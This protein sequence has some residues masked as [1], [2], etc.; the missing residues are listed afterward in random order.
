M[1]KIALALLLSLGVTTSAYAWGDRE[2][3]ILSGIAGILLLNKLNE[4]PV[5][6]QQQQPPI[7]ID[8]VIVSPAPPPRYREYYSCLVRVYDPRYGVFR[9]EVMTCV[10]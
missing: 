1:K 8:P 5:T 3:G 7:V 10:K 2:Q 9:N 6:Q 4:R